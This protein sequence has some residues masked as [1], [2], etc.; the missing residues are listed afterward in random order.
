[1]SS[2]LHSSSSVF[3]LQRLISWNHIFQRQTLHIPE[4]EEE[5]EDGEEELEGKEEEKEVEDVWYH[6]NW[7]QPSDVVAGNHRCGSKGLIEY[8]D[9]SNGEGTGGG[10]GGGGGGGRKKGRKKWFN[11][12]KTLTH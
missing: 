11:L 3:H 2:S 7:L 1:M 10:V 4:E 6:A 5:E 9:G 8:L 12:I